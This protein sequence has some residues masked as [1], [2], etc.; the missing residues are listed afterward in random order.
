MKPLLWGVLCCGLLW[1]TAA[2][3]AA[4][5]HWPAF[6]AFAGRFISADGRVIDPSTPQQVTTSE[7]QSYALFFA[8]VAGDRA[9][10]EQ[11]L[12]WTRDNLA[13]GN[14]TL[15]LP[16]WQW[17]HA[18]DG[19]W[20]VL[21]ANPAADADLW[22]AYD[23]L[24]AGRLWRNATYRILGKVLAHRIYDAESAV[25][26]GL[27]RTLL[28]APQGFR[29][30]EQ[31]WRLNPSY[32]PLQLLRAL[33]DEDPG[34]DWP[35]L[36]ASATRIVEDSAPAGFAPD[37]TVYD[38]ASGRFQADALTRGIGSYGAIRVYLWAGML[39]A[40][41]PARATLLQRLAPM[42]A[43]TATDGWPP[44]QV[45]TATGAVHGQGPSG[46]S[47][48]LLPFLAARG[49][50]DALRVQRA[51][52][53]ASA[54]PPAGYYNAV[55]TLFGEGA[56]EQRFAFAANGRLLLPGDAACAAASH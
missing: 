24:Q 53:A 39:A 45:D 36:L 31:R 37:W 12:Q 43:A 4:C 46:F 1:A 40:D 44:R 20:Q 19:R 9:R 5:P 30:D 54:W 25:I 49:Q 52:V 42:G 6:D 50:A 28:P 11:I 48:A 7:G 18:A 27:G 38:A 34:R 51:R 15:H 13:Q 41:D 56:V 55:L 14:L 35:V 32:M 8:L 21:D 29:L 16:A 33:A 23:L 26:P 47:A 10:F 17:G 22:L 2:A 3:A